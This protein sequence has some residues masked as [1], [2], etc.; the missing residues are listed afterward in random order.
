MT[1]LFR[2]ATKRPIVSADAASASGPR[3]RGRRPLP[4]NE[5][6]CDQ[7]PASYRQKRNLLKHLLD[8]HQAREQV[9]N[10]YCLVPNCGFGCVHV[11]QLRRHLKYE[12]NVPISVEHLRFSNTKG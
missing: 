6:K 9:V 5:F 3:K 8:A 4:G 12:H 1:L 10:M 11:D 2:R 7:C